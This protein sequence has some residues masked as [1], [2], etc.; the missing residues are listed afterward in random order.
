MIQK[1]DN[2]IPIYE[3]GDFIWQIQGPYS[4]SKAVGSIL[5]SSL[6]P[7]KLGRWTGCMWHGLIWKEHK[8]EGFLVRWSKS[9]KELFVLDTSWSEWDPVMPDVIVD[10]WKYCSVETI[11]TE[12]IIQND[13]EVS[14]REINDFAWYGPISE[15]NELYIPVFKDK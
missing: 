6:I 1:P 12:I 9:K 8:D 11:F 4:R 2:N 15:V 10:S 3:E 7:S 13:L 5:L 14:L